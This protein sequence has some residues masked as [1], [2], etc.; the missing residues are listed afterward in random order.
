MDV[1]ISCK[2][3]KKTL[4]RFYERKLKTPIWLVLFLFQLPPI[5]HITLQTG[6]K[7]GEVFL[8]SESIAPKYENGEE[9]VGEKSRLNHQKK[10]FVKNLLRHFN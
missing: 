5:T 4:Y 6:R 2:R 7:K 8:Y 10:C 9:V 3:I 1:T